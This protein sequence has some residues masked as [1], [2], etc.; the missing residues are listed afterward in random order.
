MP[1]GHSGANL[2][3]YRHLPAFAVGAATAAAARA[4]GFACVTH[5]D[6]D[7]AALLALLRA[8]GVERA[9]MPAGRD[10]S[11]D[12]VPPITAQVTVYAADPVAVAPED[13]VC[14]TGAVALL[15]STRIARR[16]ADL[17]DDR[18]STM[19]AAISAPVLAAAGLGWA[20]A[21]SAPEP[22]EAAL[23]ALAMRLAD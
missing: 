22:S 8:H 9:L 13:L 18:G 14:L 21:E 5:G 6:G 19:L 20:R 4:A 3:R 23:L 16:L 1:C 11:L 12:L 7:G 10:R 2:A 17:V 15:H